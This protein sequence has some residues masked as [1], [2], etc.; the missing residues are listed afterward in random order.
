[1]R[2]D[3]LFIVTPIIGGAFGL[4]LRWLQISVIFDPETGLAARNAGLSWAL[5]TVH[6]G[7]KVSRWSLPR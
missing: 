3:T 1:M 2:K 5:V 6:P 7:C 4:F